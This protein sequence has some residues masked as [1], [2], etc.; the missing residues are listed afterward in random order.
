L[1]IE[2][3]RLAISS[4]NFSMQ[5]LVT[6]LLSV[7]MTA[8]A[9]LGCCAHHEHRNAMSHKALDAQHT[10]HCSD[11]QSTGSEKR[12]DAPQDCDEE[13]CVFVASKHSDS[14]A[15]DWMSLFSLVAF[16]YSLN[17]LGDVDS[18]FIHLA[19]EYVPY[20]EGSTLR[21]WQCV[22]VI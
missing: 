18:E 3:D 7:I 12:P 19:S 6:L 22:W 11:H 8:H 15:I 4:D 2:I 5:T 14:Q 13:N 10:C 21:V 1:A 9:V 17:H 16:S 20:H